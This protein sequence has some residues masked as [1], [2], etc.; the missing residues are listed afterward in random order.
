MLLLLCRVIFLCALGLG[1]DVTNRKYKVRMKINKTSVDKQA[2]TKNITVSP[3]TLT[4]TLRGDVFSNNLPK[5]TS[6][7]RLDEFTP[8]HTPE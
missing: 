7:C 5:I 2:E 6:W 1:S 4:L 8:T 3:L